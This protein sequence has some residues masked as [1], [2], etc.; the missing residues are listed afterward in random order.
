MV[1]SLTLL[2]LT[3]ELTAGYSDGFCWKL[4]L[5]INPADGHNFGYGASAWVDEKDI[6]NNNT[7]FTA[8]YKSYDV[9]LETANS[10]A[11]VRHQDGVCEAARVWEFK[12][13]GQTF[14]EYMDIKKTSRLVATYNST[15]TYM[16]YN[17]ANQERDPIFGVDGA[18]VFNWWSGTTDGVRIAS[19]N[20]HCDDDLPS[21]S[22]N[23]NKFFGL[24]NEIDSTAASS[25]KASSKWWGDVGN[26]ECSYG[27]TKR[28]QGTDHGTGY[29]SGDVYGQYAVYVSDDA[30]TFPCEGR[31]LRTAMYDLRFAPDFDR[32]EQ[33]GD[34]VINFA[35]FVFY[36]A[37]MNED[38]VLSR[39]EFSKARSNH[40][41]AKTIEDNSSTDFDRVDRNGDGVLDLDEIEFDSADSNRDGGLSYEE[42]HVARVERTLTDPE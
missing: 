19:S 4:A 33:D 23:T 5:N 39:L 16:S 9:T 37:D 24:G 27:Y 15:F 34:D 25:G 21:S 36:R 29:T 14:H 41:F 2:F 35:E 8:D 17:M 22:E 13:V 7:A 30:T 6:G 11:I 20:A 10:I 28:V 12:A 32:V 1:C 26:Y 40:R 3:F 42:Y 31:T 38:G 18:L